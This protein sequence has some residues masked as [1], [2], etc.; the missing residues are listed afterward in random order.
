MTKNNSIIYKKPIKVRLGSND[1]ITDELGSEWFTS[2]D[3]EDYDSLKKEYGEYDQVQD[4][5]VLNSDE[6]EFEG[7][8]IGSIE[9]NDSTY[10][11]I[12]FNEKIADNI[13]N[14]DIVESLINNNL[15]IFFNFK[16][17]NYR[18]HRLM[19][20]DEDIYKKLFDLIEKSFLNIRHK[21]IYLL[22][23]EGVYDENDSNMLKWELSKI[24]LI[25]LKNNLWTN[26]N[27]TSY[28]GF[29]KYDNKQLILVESK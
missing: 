1:C 28:S 19:F 22:K 18:K 5:Y 6:K 25:D 15:T 13:I 21:R 8:E 24:A 20:K 2:L 4:E 7:V 3:Y 10:S 27:E 29:I 9:Y 16:N 12:L 17:L 23:I 11:K 14:K 26:W